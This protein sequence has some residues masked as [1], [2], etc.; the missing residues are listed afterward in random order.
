M[1]TVTMSAVHADRPAA[2]TPDGAGSRWA[3][4]KLI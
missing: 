1:V 3:V 2:I 4:E